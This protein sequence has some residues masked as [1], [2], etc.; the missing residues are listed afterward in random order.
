MFAPSYFLKVAAVSHGKVSWQTSGS[1]IEMGPTCLRILSE[2]ASSIGQAF[3]A[4][5]RLERPA[6]ATPEQYH[7]NSAGCANR[8]VQGPKLDRT[9]AL[10]KMSDPADEIIG[11]E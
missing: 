5:Y 4:S 1:C 2:L 3:F 9:N 6:K 8:G 7:Q 11:S 10:V